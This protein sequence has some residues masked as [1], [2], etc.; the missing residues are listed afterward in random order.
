MSPYLT[1]DPGIQV[2]LADIKPGSN[3]RDAVSAFTH[4]FNGL[5]LEFVRVPCL[6]ASKYLFYLLKLRLSGICKTW[7]DSRFN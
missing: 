5:N 2:V 4:L 3:F 1:L 6:L 7:G